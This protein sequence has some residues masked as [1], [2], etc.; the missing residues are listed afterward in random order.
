MWITAI[1]RAMDTTATLILRC[2][3]PLAIMA[4]TTEA[5]AV[6]MAIMVV[7]GVDITT[8]TSQI[9]AK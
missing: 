1:I 3:F 4:V 5:I 6:A 8:N 9:T 2:H 7:A